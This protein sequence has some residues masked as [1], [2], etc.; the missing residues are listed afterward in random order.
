MFYCFPQQLSFL[1]N[2]NEIDYQSLAHLHRP[3]SIEYVFQ[4]VS[5]AC[6]ALL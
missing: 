5:R 2:R 6:P 4:F 1:V 3:P